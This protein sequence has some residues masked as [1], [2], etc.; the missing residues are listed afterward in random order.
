MRRFH[1]AIHAKIY[2][3]G[4]KYEI[5]DLKALALQKF[6][7]EA[8]RHHSTP[9]FRQGAREAY[10]STVDEDRGM[11]NVVVET[12]VK[13]RHL[14]LDAEFQSVVKETSLGFD[15]LIRFAYPDSKS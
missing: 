2:A 14:L 11:R 1:L 6:A 8:Q 9:S 15:L 7:F 5:R 3:L 10:T 13:N 12:V 4:E